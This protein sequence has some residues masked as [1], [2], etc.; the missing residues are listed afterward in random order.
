MAKKLNKKIAIIGSLI[1]AVLILGVIVVL[2]N[3]SRDPHKYIRDAETALALKEPDYKAAEKAYGQAFAYAKKNIQ[4]KIDILFK[5]ADM[6]LK[7]NEWPKVA[8]CWDK[9]INFDTSNLKARLAM[10]DYY[11]QRAT[12]GDWMA[13]KQVESNVS[14]MMDK[15]LDTTPR[16]YRI[17]GQAMLELVSR[18][19]MT[20][21][22]KGIND[23]IEN[24][25]KASQ[26]ESNNVDVYQYLASAIIQKGEILAAK[27]VLNAA[28]NARKEADKIL[29]KGVE[30]LPNEPRAYINLYNS[31]IDAAKDDQNKIKDIESNVIQLTQK[32]PNSSLPYF[33]LVRLYEKIPKE[34]EKAITSIEKARQIDKQNVS[35]ALAAANLYYRKSLI[36][37]DQQAFQKAIDIA[38]EALGY[39]DS[40][41]VPGPKARM[42][43]MYRYLLHTFLAGGYLEKAAEAPKEQAKTNNWLELAEKEVYQIDQLLGSAEHPYVVMWKGKI[44]LVKGQKN[45]AI[46]QMY[47]AYQKLTTSGQPQGDPQLGILAYD[48]AKAYENTPE[49]GAVVQFYSTALKSGIQYTKP[50]MLLDFASAMMRVQYWSPAIDALD[51]F[52]KNFGENNESRDLRISVY[53]AGNMPDKA[54]E[55][56]NKLSEN[57]PNILRLKNLFLNGEI[58]KTAWEVTQKQ[59]VAGQPQNEQY[60]Q[61]KVKYEQMRNEGKRVRDKLAAIGTSKITEAEFVDVCKKYINDNENKK[62]VFFVD[63]YLVSHPNSVNVDLYK[64]ILAEPSPANVPPERTDQIYVQTFEAVK[65]PIQQAI[66]FGRFYQAKGKNE[67]AVEYYQKILKLAPDNSQAITNLFDIALGQQDFVQAQNLAEIARKNNTDFCEGEFFKARLAFAKKEYQTAIEKINNSLVKNPISSEAYLLRSQVYTAIE[68]ESDAI[69]DAKKAYSLNPLN[70]AVTRNVAYVLFSR[71]QKLG[72]AATTDQVAETRSALEVA[73]RA[74]PSDFNLRS[75][76]AQFISPTEPDRAIAI[77][78]QIQKVLPTV[79]NSLRLGSLAMRLVEQSKSQSQKDLYIGIAR[80]AYKKAYELAPNDIRVLDSYADYLKNSGKAEEGEKILTGHNDLLWRFYVRNGKIDDAKKILD[81][82]YEANPQ[83]TN[84]VKGLIFVSRNKNDQ[85]GILK[86][87]ADLLKVDKSLDNQIIQIESCLET[88]LSDEAKAKLESLREKYPDEPRLIFLQTWLTA[89]QGKL[90]EALKLANR[91]LELDKNNA[92]TWR[93]R[94]QINLGL[95]NYNDAINDLQKSKSLTDNADVRID[96]A[97]VYTRTGKDEQAV[98]ELKLAVDEQGSDTARNMLEE[99]YYKIGNTDRL[100]KFYKETIEKFPDGVYWY[101]HAGEFSLN[102]KNFDEAYKFFDIAFKNSLKINSEAPDIGAFDGKMRALLDG[103]KYDQLLAEATKYLDGSLAPIAYERMAE[104]KAHTGEKDSAVQYFRRALEKAGTNENLIVEILRL[105]NYVVGVDETVKWC[106]EK[107]QSQPDSLPVNLA[108]FN[109]YNMNQQYNKSLEYI[110]VCIRVATDEHIK[111]TCQMNK[112][113]ILQEIFNKTADKT[114]IEKAIKEYESI[115]QKQPTNT[116]VLNNL[117]YVLADNNLDIG[118]ALEYAKKAYDAVPNNTD[119]LDTYGYVLLKNDKIKEADEFMQRA[120]QQFEQN[121]MNAPTAVY[122]HI[123]LVKEKLGQDAEALEAYKRAMEF[124][125]KDVSKNVKDRI[126]AAIERLSSKKK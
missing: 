38:T 119:V 126:S 108:L 11:Y 64:R 82:L 51:F 1:F 101:N 79:D 34:I 98:V 106:N 7:M 29:L 113:A 22:E 73:I 62:A 21:K 32:F 6:Y 76:Y 63:N 30:V 114:Y 88:G 109:L 84:T 33:E 122:E 18:G 10:L 86:Y 66:L 41:D 13:W 95:N 40:L 120:L 100:L 28:E 52:D 115:L 85:A 69:D 71:N 43:F 96:L 117:A 61:L 37:K 123:A 60:Q 97:R 68:K 81:K 59:P 105:M 110:D 116:T 31:K 35:Y 75:F 99:L 111:L 121:K 107:L 26:A 94:G 93:L 53:I 17:K 47:T 54:Q 90:A 15:K 48:L 36:N 103:K 14:E 67:Q 118:K 50:K 55:M 49:T 5:L 77:S 16:M 25:Q 20:D 80:D 46:A 39:P 4:L 102:T 42:S 27:G 57:E 91:N 56:L 45:E 104:A 125:G 3:L 92:R 89:R 74:N 8:G 87:S 12:S 70:S 83:D 19:Q 78:Q 58:N 124:A 112:A 72:S 24:L 23:A 9:I 44:L 2:L 65:E